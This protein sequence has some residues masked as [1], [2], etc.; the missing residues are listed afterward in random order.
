MVSF[1]PMRLATASGEIPRLT[2]T[3]DS[4]GLPKKIFGLD[5]GQATQADQVR[6]TVGQPAADIVCGVSKWCQPAGS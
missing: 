6:R 4:L 2:S 1:R 3:R 5:D